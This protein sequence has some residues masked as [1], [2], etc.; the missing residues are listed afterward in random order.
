MEQIGVIGSGKFGTTIASLLSVKHPVL[1]YARNKEVVHKINTY[2][3]HFGYQLNPKIIATSDLERL[4]GECEVIFPVV[5]SKNFRSMMREIS[6]YLHPFHFVIH[7]TKGFDLKDFNEKDIS[8]L[9]LSR[10]D[11]HTMSEVICQESLVRRI[12]ALSG[13]NLSKEIMEGQPAATVLA[14]EFD[15]VIAR[16]QSILS[17]QHFFVFG[18]HDL[19]GCEMSGAL[20]N[21]F[22]IGSGIIAG[23]GLGKNVQSLII[24]RG[25]REMIGLGKQMGATSRSFLGTAGI[26]DLVA[27]ATS[28]DSR[29]FSLGYNIAKGKTLNQVLESTNEIAEGVRTLKIAQQLGKYYQIRQPITQMIYSVVFEN[30]SIEKAINY[31]MKYPYSPDVDFL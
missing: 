19:L 5:P 21:I 13:P 3:E 16:G 25:L 10:K 24:T 7:G 4:A 2:H 8:T 31:L 15:E 1:L 17:G 12:G 6:R 28:I 18:S 30:L 23:V 29:N 14:S 9:E 27:T 20:K 11:V 26:G 22:A